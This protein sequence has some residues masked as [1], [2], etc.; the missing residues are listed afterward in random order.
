VDS[1]KTGLSSGRPNPF[2]D[3]TM[4]AVTLEESQSVEVA[5]FDLVG[6]RVATLHRGV[7]PVGT[8]TLAWNGRRTDGSRAPGGIY[9]YQLK[10]PGQVINRRVVL[11]ATP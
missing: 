4:F 10:R 7:L 11:L 2:R 1:S 3:E 9:F 8:T 5:V 6:R